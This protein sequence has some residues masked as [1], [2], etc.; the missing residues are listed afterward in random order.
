MLLAVT[1]PS[2]VLAPIVTAMTAIVT[3]VLVQLGVEAS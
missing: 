1:T 2:V 3:V